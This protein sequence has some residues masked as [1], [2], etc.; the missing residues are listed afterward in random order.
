M[1]RGLESGG[2]PP[3]NKYLGLDPLSLAQNANILW[4]KKKDA[5]NP[6]SKPVALGLTMKNEG[7]EM[8]REVFSTSSDKSIAQDINSATR[9]LSYKSRV[10]FLYGFGE[11]VLGSMLEAL[12]KGIFEWDDEAFFAYLNDAITGTPIPKI[13]LSDAMKI[14]RSLPKKSAEDQA[15]V[16]R[17]TLKEDN[18][19]L[20]FLDDSSIQNQKLPQTIYAF[21]Y[22]VQPMAGKCLK[23]VVP[24]YK[25]ALALLG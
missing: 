13:N 1:N 16:I 2:K 15:K 5:D 3:E 8:L 20:A 17:E 25:A 22:N 6:V 24:K 7:R 11:V 10:K 4:L 23:L 21:L 18:G 19:F 14:I 9:E 12:E